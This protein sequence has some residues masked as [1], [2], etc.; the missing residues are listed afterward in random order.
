MTRPVTPIAL[1]KAL[2]C[3]SAFWPMLASS[4]SSTSCGA[5]RIGLGDHALDLGDLF[6]QVQLGRQATGGVGQHDIDIARA[7]GIDGIEHHRGRVAGLLR[8]HGDA[9]ALAPGFQLFARGGAE[10]VAGGQQH[11]LALAWKC[12]ASLPIEVVLPAPLT[13][14]IMITKG[15]CR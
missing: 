7:G 3:C 6:H 12:L 15:L 8:D 1:S 10:G 5:G 9:V 11:A 2:T 4:T 13:P 14:A